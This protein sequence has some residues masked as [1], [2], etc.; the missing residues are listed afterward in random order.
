MQPGWYTNADESP[1]VSPRSFIEN[2]A[3]TS[4]EHH[5]SS[6]GHSAIKILTK[7]I[8]SIK[9]KIKKFEEEFEAAFGYRP[10][11]SDKMKHKDIK[12]YMSELSKARK[13]LKRKYL[14]TFY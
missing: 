7:N 1:V 14:S 4:S 3:I 13:E 6:T 10:S 9:R 11:H 2:N 5:F 8:N 12:K